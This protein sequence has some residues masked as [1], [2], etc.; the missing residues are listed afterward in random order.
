M[1]KT[2]PSRLAA[3]ADRRL[4]AT[5][6]QLCDAFGACAAL[7]PVYRRL[8]HL[9][10]EELRL[11]EA[12]S[13]QLDQEMAQLLRAHQSA[14]QRLAEVPGLGV[15]SAQQIIA[16]VGAGAETF[17]SAKHLASWVG[18]CP[19]DARKCRCELQPPLAPR[20]PADAPHPQSSRQR[21][22]QDQ[23]EYTSSS[24]FGAWFRAWATRRPS[25]RLPIVCVV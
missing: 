21:G 7:H 12:Q 10:L 24:C 14:V 5:P 16:E 2:E 11:V 25:G 18:V 22:R 19:G 3:L 17:P 4:R 20:Q 13:A 9:A 23:G 15:D 1:G 6:E 8:I